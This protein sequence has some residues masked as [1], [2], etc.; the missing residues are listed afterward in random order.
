[1]GKFPRLFLEYFGDQEP[2]MGRCDLDWIHTTT[3]G[4]QLRFYKDQHKQ[5]SRLDEV[6]D[7]IDGMKGTMT[8]LPVSTPTLI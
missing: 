7:R 3:I 2:P 8:S 6:G 1:V 5:G 4:Y